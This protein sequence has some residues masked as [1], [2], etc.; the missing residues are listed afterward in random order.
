LTLF[1]PIISPSPANKYVLTDTERTHL[2]R[3][4]PAYLCMGNGTDSEGNMGVFLRKNVIETAGAALRANLT[5]LAPRVLPWRELVSAAADPKRVPDLTTAFDTFLLHTGGRGVLDALQKA[6]SLDDA[7]MRHSRAALARFG[8]TSAA[9]LWYVLAHV[10]AFAGVKKGQRFLGVSFGGGFKCN[11]M[12]LK[13]A[14]AVAAGERHPAWAP[15]DVPG[16]A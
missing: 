5:R 12:C 6:L 7:A 16:V 11:S 10:E 3:Q 1:L 14:R 2:G 15:M 13:A 8:N 4:D 9:S